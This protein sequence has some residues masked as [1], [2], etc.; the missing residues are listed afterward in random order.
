MSDSAMTDL[1][2]RVLEDIS[3]NFPVDEFP[4]C[5]LAERV[6]STEM[7]VLNS[8]LKLRESGAVSRIA[9]RLNV[10]EITFCSLL[11]EEPDAT[12]P[13]E[14]RPVGAELSCEEQEL[15]ALLQDDLPWSERPYAELAGMLSMRGLEVDQ[16]WVVGTLR[17]WL[18]SGLL[19]GIAAAQN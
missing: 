2:R 17:A 18:K 19:E 16:E 10:A 9:A 8:V 1:D 3:R 6:G 15:A 7:D 13:A 11:E 14:V 12:G 5:V 4:Y